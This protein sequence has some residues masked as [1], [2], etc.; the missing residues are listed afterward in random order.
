MD[1]SL[2]VYCW[3]C[4]LHFIASIKMFYCYVEKKF[5]FIPLNFI[6]LINILE[7]IT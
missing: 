2:V 6:R 3:S 1:Q 4:V 5:G 7:D